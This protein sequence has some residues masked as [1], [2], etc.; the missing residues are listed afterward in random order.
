MK[1]GDIREMP[2]NLFTILQALEHVGD[3][4]RELNH[5][6]R[7]IMSQFNQEVWQLILGS[8]QEKPILIENI[9]CEN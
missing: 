5:Q 1:K 9:H 3:N 4:L 7:N 8:F 6:K 2:D